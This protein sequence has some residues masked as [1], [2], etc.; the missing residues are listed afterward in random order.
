MKEIKGDIWDIAKKNGGLIIIPTNGFIK[1]N[2][3]CVMGRGLAYQA[4]TKYTGLAKKLGDATKK[5]GN[6]PH[7]FVEEKLIAFPVKHNWWEK[8][9]LALIEASAI[10]L[11]EMIKGYPFT[12]IPILMPHVGCGNGKLK[13]EEVKPIIEKHLGDMHNIIICDNNE[14]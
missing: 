12:D 5:Y 1:T 10:R 2:G 8:A 9:D 7:I 14:G 13:W 6:T 4:K 3:E 11:R